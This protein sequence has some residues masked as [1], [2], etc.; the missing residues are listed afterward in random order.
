VPLFTEVAG[1]R[2]KSGTFLMILAGVGMPLGNLLGGWLTDRMSPLRATG[3]L[4]LAMTAALFTMPVA[5]QSAAL[6]VL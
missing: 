4:L 1:F 2:A 3:W 6:G 5:A